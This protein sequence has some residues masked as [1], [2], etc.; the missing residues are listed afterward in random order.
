[1]NRIHSQRT[2]VISKRSLNKRMR[3]NTF[4][5]GIA[6]AL[7]LSLMGNVFG[8]SP[9][10]PAPPPDPLVLGNAAYEKGDFSAAA[11]HYKK[12]AFEGRQSLYRAFA[13]FNL[14]NCQVQT[15]SLP[16]AIVCYRRSLE[17]N[18]HFTRAWRLL[19]DVYFQ[20]NAIGE[21][22]VCYRRVLEEEPEDG[23]AQRMLGECA[24][25]GGDVVE[26]LRR[27]DAAAKVEPDRAEN[28][29]AQAEAL[30]T[31]RDFPAAESTLEDALFRLPKPS[32]EGFFYLGYLFERE[33]DGEGKS[34]DKA[35]R[36]YEEGLLLAPRR[37]EY[38]ERIAGLQERQDHDFLA[39]LTY[40]RAV[41]AGI[42]PAT[43]HLRMG[44]IYFDQG[45]MEKAAESFG[46]A[47]IGGEPRGRTGL[48]N[49]AAVWHNSGK[50]QRSDSLLSV[51]RALP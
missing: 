27:L 17:N 1:M 34:V 49:I 50:T 48:E 7:S 18:P 2:N 21:A 23:H 24:L 46:H 8:Q 36:A 29:L 26:A 19:G 15:E 32:A 47:W 45:R 6:F 10:P 39:L 51:I 22:T 28:Y 16:R 4:T 43:F 3:R 25:R 13:W 42:K 41:K 14:G 11:N 38:Y 30:E 12:A 20:L 31:I 5:L 9:S 33:G 35:I 37:A 44:L 40:E